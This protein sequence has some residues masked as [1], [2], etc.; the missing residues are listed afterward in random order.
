M[1]LHRPFYYLSLQPVYEYEQTQPYNVNKV[2]VPSYTFEAEVMLWR[3]VAFHAAQQDHDQ[4]NG[5]QCHMET[6]ET[7]QHEEGSAI[8]T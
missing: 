3:E 1:L 6:V 8:S 2:P 4:H 5:T 7:C